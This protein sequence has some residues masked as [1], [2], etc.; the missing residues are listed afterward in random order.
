M[1]YSLK[2]KCFSPN[3]SGLR[4]GRNASE[5][6]EAHIDRI[7]DDLEKKKNVIGFYLD[8]STTIDTVIPVNLETSWTCL[9]S[10]QESDKP[11]LRSEF[12]EST[13]LAR[14]LG[15]NGSTLASQMIKKDRR[16]EKVDYK[17][18]Y[19]EDIELES[20]FLSLVLHGYYLKAR[21]HL[22]DFYGS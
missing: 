19:D 9:I 6:I 4:P 18:D 17:K 7:V 14:L 1:K 15:K 13:F 10:F 5:A 8:V 11:S 20:R 12:F 3:Q 21:R 2:Q 22:L 16:L